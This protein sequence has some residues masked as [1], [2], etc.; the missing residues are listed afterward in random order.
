MES[1]SFKENPLP[2]WR[3]VFLQVERWRIGFEVDLVLGLIFGSMDYE[4][5]A[6]IGFWSGRG[7]FE[8]RN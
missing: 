2:R 6:R 8:L 7:F 4:R 3:F 1:L 5:R